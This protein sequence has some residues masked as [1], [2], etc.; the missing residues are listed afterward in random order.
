MV[1]LSKYCCFGPENISFFLPSSLL[2]TLAECFP[3][4]KGDDAHKTQHNVFYCSLVPATQ[5]MLRTCSWLAYAEAPFATA[6]HPPQKPGPWKCKVQV[7]LLTRSFWNGGR[8]SLRRKT[9]D[10]YTPIMGQQDPSIF[11]G[12]LLSPAHVALAL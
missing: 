11:P 8:R 10:K 9:L 6:A 3:A 4:A 2:F 7:L 5:D 1:I 12:E